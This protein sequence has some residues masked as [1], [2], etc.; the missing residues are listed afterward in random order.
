MDKRKKAAAKKQVLKNH[1]SGKQGLLPEGFIMEME[2]LL[3]TEE[4][5]RLF[6]SLD[7]EPSVSIRVNRRKASPSD[8]VFRE[9]F[10]EAEPVEWCGSG[11]YLP[12][13]HDFVHDPLLH[14][15]VYYVQEAAS[16]IY[17]PISERL[18]VELVTPSSDRPRRLD[19]LDLCAAP[20]GKSTAMLNGLAIAE[21]K[22]GR[23]LP[24]LLVSNEY[25]RKRVKALKENLDKWGDPN[26]IITN[27]PTDRFASLEGCFD[28]VAVD[29]PCSGEG[30]MRRLPMART[31]WSTALVEQCVTLQREI[32]SDAV[33]ALRPGG[34]LIYSTCTFNSREDE[35]NV[36]WLCEC[37]GLEIVEKP[38]HFFPHRER[39]EGL[40]VA[41]LQK[42]EGKPGATLRRLG[43]NDLLAAGIPVVSDGIEMTL[44]R[45]QKQGRKD[46]TTAIPSPRQVL[47]FDYDRGKFPMVE[48][49]RE[50]AVA[51]LRRNALR[52]P[53]EVAKG[54]VAV[55]YKGYPLGLV[56]NVGTRANNLLPA[57]WRLLT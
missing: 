30:M 26:A 49:D 20:G 47:A 23:P 25:D 24:Y 33:E 19:V 48:L 7:S 36:S 21:Q 8:P 50:D 40:F 1:V 22:I 51:Y 14:S 2:N 16:M 39:C 31:Q 56:K 54:Y 46:D 4:A 5:S 12:V 55:A 34:F 10:P 45:Q 28:I 9:M 6:A 11:L 35:G 44:P 18:A 29:A 37:H 27:S 32:L 15:G 57:E 38:R 17:E 41:V 53:E 3:G 42:P 13:R 43:R 52:L